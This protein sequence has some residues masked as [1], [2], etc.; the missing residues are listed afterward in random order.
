M[1]PLDLWGRPE[2][3]QKARGRP[4]TWNLELVTWNLELVTWNLELVTWNPK[5]LEYFTS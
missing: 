1:S 5:Q 2:T 4:E 3:P